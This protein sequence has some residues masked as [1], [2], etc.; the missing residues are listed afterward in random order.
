MGASG[1]IWRWA[2]PVSSLSSL[3]DTHRGCGQNI[4]SGHVWAG[5]SHWWLWPD[6]RGPASLSPLGVSPPERAQL[7]ESLALR[8]PV[9]SPCEGCRMC[10]LSCGP[11]PQPVGGSSQWCRPHRRL[12]P[13]SRLPRWRM[14]KVT[15]SGGQQPGGRSLVGS[16]I[17]PLRRVSMCG[18]GLKFCGHFEG[19]WGLRPQGQDGAQSLGAGLTGYVGPAC[20]GLPSSSP[21]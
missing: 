10:V 6:S 11:R 3:A 2:L 5:K 1:G 7:W 21:A 17:K 4:P 8:M 19:R 16:G 15:A 13:R 12:T 14:K 20:H 18:C 9:E